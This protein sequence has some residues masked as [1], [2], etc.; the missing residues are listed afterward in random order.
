[1]KKKLTIT[2]IKRLDP[3]L[4]SVDY[5]DHIKYFFQHFLLEL[6]GNMI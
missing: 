2:N 4:C 1:M 3:F 6:R 5:A